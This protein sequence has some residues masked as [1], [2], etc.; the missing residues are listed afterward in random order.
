MHQLQPRKRIS[1]RA[2][3]QGL[4]EAMGKGV[5]QGIGVV[6]AP[7][8]FSRREIPAD[9]ADGYDRL[10][11]DIL[12]DDVVFT[13]SVVIDAAVALLPADRDI[14]ADRQPIDVEC[15]VHTQRTTLVLA[16]RAGPI[17]FEIIE[18]HVVRIV[19]PA[20]GETEIRIAELCR[21]EHRLPPIRPGAARHDQQARVGVRGGVDDERPPK[22]ILAHNG[23]RI[24]VRPARHLGT[25]RISVDRQDLGRQRIEGPR[26]GITRVRIHITALDH[27]KILERA[28]HQHVVQ[29]AG[30]RRNAGPDV[31][32][33]L[34][35]TRPALL[36]LDNHDAVAGSR[37]V[38]RRA[39]RILQDLDFAD[40]GGVQEVQIG[41]LHRSPVDDVQRIV[42]V[43]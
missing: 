3:G 20:A 2:V 35:A 15:R 10:H 31:E 23:R 28:L 38:N 9:I 13:D 6:P 4:I 17:L 30:R 42:V 16:V 34:P 21:T 43:E 41:L 1:D 39:R 32:P 18:G 24:Y 25:R 26:N 12:P 40:V 27:V 14:L 5:L 36:R 8:E 37:A 19:G 29:P 7:Y 33:S 11:Q 22:G